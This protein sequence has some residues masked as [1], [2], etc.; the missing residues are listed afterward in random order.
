MIGASTDESSNKSGK[1]AQKRSE[2]ASAMSGEG[3]IFKGIDQ[4]PKRPTQK[5]KV[6]LMSTQDRYCPYTMEITKDRVL[7]YQHSCEEVDMIEVALSKLHI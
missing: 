6:F 5:S 2:S 3:Q 4:K 7:L 1:G